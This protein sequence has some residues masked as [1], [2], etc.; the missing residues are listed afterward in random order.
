MSDYDWQSR[1]TGAAAAGEKKVRRLLGDHIG[2]VTLGVLFLLQ[3]LVP[4]VSAGVRN[5]FTPAYLFS[6]LTSL[7]STLLG[8]Y[9]FVPNG[10]N[11]RLSLPESRATLAAW[12]EESDRVRGAGKLTR[13]GAYCRERAEQEAKL[14]YER[15]VEALVL[16]GIERGT[17]ETVW[18]HATRKARRR[19]RRRGEL[20]REQAKLLSRIKPPTVRPL[21]PNR[22]LEGG[23]EDNAGAA[24]RGDSPYLKRAMAG[25]PVV[26]VL[27][28]LVQS[29]FY[30]DLRQDADPVVILCG[31][32]VRV[33]CVCCAALSGYRTGSRAAACHLDDVRCRTVFLAA[34]NEQ[35]TTKTGE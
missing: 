21:S 5:P 24:L 30:P 4:L 11:D 14:T 9:L 27:S 33:F 12:R 32:A 8:Y 7:F 31:V 35:E 25:K 13:F 17:Y 23:G 18:R 28:V 20:T 22:I 26:C 29:F 15:A 3:I 6:T 34:F 2:A 10:Q 16:A 1:L 19:A